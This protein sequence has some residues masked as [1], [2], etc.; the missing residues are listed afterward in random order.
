MAQFA[1][2]TRQ[3]LRA[4]LANIAAAADI[5]RSGEIMT[6]EQGGLYVG[7]GATAKNALSR[8]ARLNEVVRGPMYRKSSLAF[9]PNAT[10]NTDGASVSVT[11]DAGYRAIFP[12]A[13]QS[14]ATGVGSETLTVTVTATFNDSSTRTQTVTHS[15]SNSQSVA[16][17]NLAVDG[18]YITSIS[19]VVHS[20]ISSSAA[21]CTLTVVGLNI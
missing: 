4:T 21:S 17:I 8:A 9:T 12:S 13:I 11:A 14:Q 19:A 10:A 16:L 3:W 18:K 20:S 5:L 7:D 2:G 15:A 6:D 1:I